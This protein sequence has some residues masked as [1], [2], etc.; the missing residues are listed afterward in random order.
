MRFLRDLPI[1]RKLTFITMLTSGVALL[2]ACA[3]FVTYELIVFKK[4]MV[5]D[6]LSTAKMV[7]DSSSAALSFN[8][9]TSAEQTLKALSAHPHMR[10][11]AIFDKDGKLFARYERANAV[12]HV[13]M[14]QIRK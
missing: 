6:H 5:S 10:F 11:G 12:D 8:E 1:K 9:P 14:P 4:T 13:E 3:A 7:A 2:L